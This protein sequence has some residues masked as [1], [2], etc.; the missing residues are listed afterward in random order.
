MLTA[1]VLAAG[2]GK[3]M[4]SSL[5]KVMHPI[6]GRPLLHYS[7]QAA[8]DAGAKKVVVVLSPGNEELVSAYL[9]ETFAA[10]IVT[11]TIQDPPRGTGDAA[12][13]GLEALGD[14]EGGV[15]TLCGD[16]PLLRATDLT[17]LVEAAN[18]DDVRV[19][20]MSCDLDDPSGYGRV[21][22]D[23]DGHVTEIREDR[24]LKSEAQRATTE[25]NAGVYLVEAAA[26]RES[27]SKIDSSN[28]Q[29]EYYL[30]DIVS[31]T[32]VSGR[33][34]VAVSGA[35]TA[36][37]GVND[38]FQLVACEEQL[39]ARAARELALAGARVASSA[40]VDD[41]VTVE[42]GATLGPGVCLRGR[43]HIASGAVLDVG[44]VVT[45]STIAENAYVKPYSVITESSVGLGAQ[46]GPF[47]H[48]RP[49]SD[50]GEDAH[51]G[52][53]V[54][55]KKTKLHKGAKANH[56]AYLGDGDVGE[57]A[58]IGAGTIF[59]NYDGF[60]KSKTIIGKDAFIGSDSQLVAP[61]TIG[62]GAYVATGATV[63]TDVPA[64]ALAIS[65]VK[66]DNKLGYASRLKSRLKGAADKKK[67][68]AAKSDS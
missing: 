49:G 33:H 45:D 59:C 55:T 6:A 21:L 3:R 38:Q 10:G 52:N 25:I 2:Q 12:R 19:A 63:T 46:I 66:Q 43:T 36:M 58:N 23:A 57:R 64:D 11:T 16:T 13:V 53:F 42:T 68:E 48:L 65:R 39:Y 7:V 30:T 29:S 61:L 35:I 27:L 22:R 32:R 47:A 60:S 8:I 26:F 34:V 56:L 41:T 24:D 9:T 28:A 44:T 50:I 40:R 31:L 17:P 54:E 14:I 67:A 18:A 15:L 5:S 1:I 20:F 37:Q 4:K 62:D 51:V